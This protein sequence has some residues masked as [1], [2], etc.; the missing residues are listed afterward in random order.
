M[1]EPT[2]EPVT[3]PDEPVVTIEETQNESVRDSIAEA[4]ARRAQPPAAEEEQ[5]RRFALE[6]DTRQE[7]RRLIDPG[8]ARGNTEATLE[9]TLKMLSTI[10]NNLLKEPENE[11]FKRFKPTNPLIQKN[12]VDVKGALEFAIALG[13]RAE[14][15]QFQPYYTFLATPQN[16]DRLRIGATVLTETLNRI[17][18]KA[19]LARLNKVDPKAVQKEIAEKV[20]LA[21]DD[22]RYES[23]LLEYPL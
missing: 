15:V 17:A 10:A 3:K 23:F 20:K 1:S 16:Q 18:Q 4:I 14:V 22:D 12:L 21:Y 7:F 2:T 6:R 9:S 19:E 5:E 13:F 8:I 11:K